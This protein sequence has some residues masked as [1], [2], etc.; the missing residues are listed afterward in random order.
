MHTAAQCRQVGKLVEHGAEHRRTERRVGQGVHRVDRA[1]LHR[2]DAPVVDPAA[3]SQPAQ[4][5]GAYRADLPDWQQAA[6]EQVTVLDQA[7]AQCFPI[8]Q[9]RRGI[10]QLIHTPTVSGGRRSLGGA[11]AWGK[12]GR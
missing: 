8:V 12:P 4:H 6:E 7:A 11:A 9:Q 10:G 5:G 2:R 3:G 1:R